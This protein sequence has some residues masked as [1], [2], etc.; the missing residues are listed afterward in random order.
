MKWTWPR[1]N[2]YRVA[3]PGW[4]F[5]WNDYDYRSQGGALYRIGAAVV[6]GRWCYGVRWAKPGRNFGPEAG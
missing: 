4:R 5:L 6:L 2:R 3:E 1:V